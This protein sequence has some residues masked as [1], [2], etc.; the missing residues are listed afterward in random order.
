LCRGNLP[1]GS[2]FPY[3][4]PEQGAQR[5]EDHR[6]ARASYG[7]KRLCWVCG[8]HGLERQGRQITT[9]ADEV[10]QFQPVCRRQVLFVHEADGFDSPGG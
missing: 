10:R 3:P 9:E 4:S 5:D 6:P 7:L 8:R 1:Q 2:R